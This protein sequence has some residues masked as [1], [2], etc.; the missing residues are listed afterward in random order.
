[1]REGEDTMTFEQ[2]VEKYVESLLTGD[3]MTADAETANIESVVQAW[4]VL[5][6]TFDKIDSRL[7]GL[8]DV[9]LA[10]A[11]EF[12]RPTDKGGSK[13]LVNGTTVLR[14]RRLAALPDEKGLRGLLEK[15]GI[16][17]DQAFSKVTKVVL[18]ASKVQALVDLGK[19]PE[20]DVAA[21]RKASWA[22]FVQAN[23]E[24]LET[25]DRMVGEAGEEIVE[26]SP[27][28]KRSKV[29]GDRKGA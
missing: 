22:L 3:I 4:V 15:H 24:L 25:L 14:Q 2:A 8:R 17:P 6:Y 9:L 18:D 10:R 11:E 5:K 23:E 20:A 16:K 26:K 12:G 1:M 21:L 7:K 19:V 13:L 27:R 28:Q 29:S